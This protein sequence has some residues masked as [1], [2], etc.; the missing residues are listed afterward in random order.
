MGLPSGVWRVTWVVRKHVGNDRLKKNRIKRDLDS[1]D[2]SD[3]VFVVRP[4]LSE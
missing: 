3:V 4:N 2:Y 1:T